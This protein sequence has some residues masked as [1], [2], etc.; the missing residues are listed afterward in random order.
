MWLVAVALAHTT[1]SSRRAWLGS[2]EINEWLGPRKECQTWLYFGT[3]CISTGFPSRII[4]IELNISRRGIWLG[5]VFCSV[6]SSPYH[7][8]T[9][10]QVASILRFYWMGWLHATS[11]AR[12]REPATNIF[13]YSLVSHRDC[14]PIPH[15]QKPRRS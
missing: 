5:V 7:R 1:P 15:F 10:K 3:L 4:Y 2:S 14:A 13:P 6:C 9:R 11:L 8:T 12:L